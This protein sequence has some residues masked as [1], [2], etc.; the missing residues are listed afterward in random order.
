MYRFQAVLQRLALLLYPRFLWCVR[1]RNRMYWY[2][3]EG[4]FTAPFEGSN[5][6]ARLIFIGA[7]VAGGV[8]FL[9]LLTT[10]S[11]EDLT[12]PVQRRPMM[13]RIFSQL[14]SKKILSLLPFRSFRPWLI[15]SLWASPSE[16]VGDD[17]VV[18]SGAAIDLIVST[19]AGFW[20]NPA[21]LVPHQ[22][23]TCFSGFNRKITN[24]K[25]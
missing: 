7:S 8:I 25:V 14:R 11:G 23:R 19:A 13:L 1:R 20:S 12:S 5:N 15:R 18:V 21:V 6:P 4:A 9:H 22:P 3:H 17:Y 16:N 2:S 10:L 24:R